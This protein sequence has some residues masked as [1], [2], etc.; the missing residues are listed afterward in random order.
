MHS[1]A[2]G[3]LLLLC[4]H[5]AVAD[6]TF[7]PRTL[8]ETDDIPLNGEDATDAGAALV[9]SGAYAELRQAAQTTSA[10]FELRANAALT[11]LLEGDLTTADIVLSHL[12]RWCRTKWTKSMP[13]NDE[14]AWLHAPCGAVKKNLFWT[15]E[16]R[17]T[18]FQLWDLQAEI[19]DTYKARLRSALRGVG[20]SMGKALSVYDVGLGDAVCKHRTLQEQIQN[21]CSE[22]MHGAAATT[23]SIEDAYL[24]L[25]RRGLT[26]FLHADWQNAD[27]RPYLLEEGLESDAKACS[28]TEQSHVPPAQACEQPWGPAWRAAGV[29]GLASGKEGEE[30]ERQR[31]RF[32]TTL[33]VADLI[34]L[35]VVVD[36]ILT[37]NVKGDFMEAGVFRGGA[38]IMLRGLLAAKRD[39][40]RRVY[41]A[42][43]FAG[44]P[45][46][47]RH[48]EDVSTGK[49][50]E[51]ELDP[52]FDWVDR[53][54]AGEDLVRYNFRRYGLLD[55]RVKFLRGFFN[56]SL[57]PVFGSTSTERPVTINNAPTLAL[58]RIDADAYD[59][60]LDALEGAYHRLSP[61]GFV[62]ID[63]WHLGGARAAVHA[64][65]RRF[66]IKGPIRS[67]PSD[68]VLTCST[69]LTAVASC[70]TGRALLAQS[71]AYTVTVLPHVAYWRKGWDE[72][73][74]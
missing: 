18:H 27:W 65:R 59:G 33:A 42:D 16:T 35:E 44:I 69:D 72:P 13:D 19:M 46:P 29:S 15:L 55:H 70:A 31:R 20:T 62:I 58:L 56:E 22:M 48:I 14:I 57:P 41:V 25:L 17:E 63:D 5:D 66:S 71:K 51:P 2:L 64:F 23:L 6:E 53:F 10:S 3:A 36:T 26:N 21:P 11:Y 8:V 37:D 73:I 30:A 9:K 49:V 39:V 61:G 50:L 28:V 47:R 67:S 74:S 7:V 1:H 4:V 43:S 34:H 12:A 60:V 38:C 24:D 54:V 45:P 40:H 32:Q 52:T 68:L